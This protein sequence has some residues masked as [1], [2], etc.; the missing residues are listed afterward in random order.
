VNI[1]HVNAA[2]TNKMRNGNKH[3][4]ANAEKPEVINEYMASKNRRKSNKTLPPFSWVYPD[5]ILE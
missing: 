5:N 4:T 1:L 3:T 2:Y